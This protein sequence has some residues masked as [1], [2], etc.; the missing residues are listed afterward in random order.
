MRRRP[1]A[2]AVAQKLEVAT[3]EERSAALHEVLPRLGVLTTDVFG[4]YVVQKFLDHGTPE[5][6]QRIAEQLKG[7]VRS[8]AAPGF[9][10]GTE[11]RRGG[12]ALSVEEADEQLGGKVRGHAARLPWGQREVRGSSGG[13]LAACYACAAA[14]RGEATALTRLRPVRAARRCSSCRFKCTGAAWCKRRSRCCRQTPRWRCSQSWTATSCDA[15]GTRCAAGPGAAP[16]VRLCGPAS[17]PT[18]FPPCVIRTCA[19]PPS[20]S[21]P[22]PR[23]SGRQGCAASGSA[24]EARRVCCCLVAQNGNHVI[25][26]I[27]ECVPTAR[28]SAVLDNFLTCVVPLSTHPFGCRVMQRIL[29]HCTDERRRVSCLSHALAHSSTRPDA[30]SLGSVVRTVWTDRFARPAR[31]T[32]RV[33]PAPP[34][35]GRAGRAALLL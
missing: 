13:P 34:P 15:C 8:R 2:V 3:P 33:P 28:I 17:L 6:R 16:P 4:N 5:E 27:I 19:S 35:P 12:E 9:G 1:C 11:G 20:R 30:S 26:K 7:Q 32:A 25:Q 21:P 29:E 14:V 10:A 31:R 18:L 24:T 23:R 22:T